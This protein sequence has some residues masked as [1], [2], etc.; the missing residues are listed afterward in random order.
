MSNTIVTK[1]R[2]AV[3]DD[4]VVVFNLMISCM[5]SERQFDLTKLGIDLNSLPSASRKL[6][7]ERIFPKDFLYNYSRLRDR[8]NAVLERGAAVRLDMGVVSSRTEAV[9]KIE[10]LDK[11]KVDWLDQLEKHSHVYTDICNKRISLIAAEAFNDGVAADV[12]N[13]LVDAL[14]KR[15]PTWEHFLSRMKFAYSPVPIKLE[16]DEDKADFDPVLYKAQREGLVAL[17]E[18]VFGGLIQY[19]SRESSDILKVLNNKKPVNGFY[20]INYRTVAR[21]GEVT[22]KL[23]GLSFVHQHVAPLA[24]VIDEALNFMPKSVEKDLSMQP[25]Q[26]YNLIACLEAMGDQHAL[27]ARL[28]DKQPLV[29]VSHSPSAQVGGAYANSQ[30]IA[31]QALASARQTLGS[32]QQLFAASEPVATSNGVVTVED[33]EQAPLDADVDVLPEVD[34]HVAAGSTF[35]GFGFTGSSMFE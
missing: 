23:H 27:L 15:Q 14:R 1:V 6:M 2:T 19:L 9:A 35:M 31:N 25:H 18:G 33:I 8:A 5:S 28:R 17:R 22:E 29:V 34:A 32:T 20:S 3:N 10:D 11:I 21:I 26:F 16:L 13:T 24:T 30:A 12:V 7:Q 4:Q